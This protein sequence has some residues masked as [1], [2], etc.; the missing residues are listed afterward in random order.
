MHIKLIAAALLLALSIGAAPFAAAE[1]SGDASSVDI[2]RADAQTI[3]DVL[4]GIGLTRAQAI[5]DYRAEYGP[6]EDVYELVNVR[7]VGE[8]TVNLNETRIRL[9]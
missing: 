2:N 4:V 1:A 7:G 9:K 5:V 6:F 8:R 3:A